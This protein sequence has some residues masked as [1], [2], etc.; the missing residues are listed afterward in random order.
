MLWVE[1]P[2]A[3]VLAPGR[4]CSPE[5]AGLAALVIVAGGLGRWVLSRR[6]ASPIV[7]LTAA[8]EGIAT[9]P[10]EA[11]SADASSDEGRVSPMRFNGWPNRVRESLATATA[12]RAEAEAQTRE[13]RALADR[14]RTAGRGG[15][16]AFG[17]S[18]SNSTN[19]CSCPSQEADAARA[20][21][22]AANGAKVEFLATNESRVANA[23][24]AIAG[25][26]D[27]LDAEVAGPVS[28]E[29]EKYLAR[30]ETGAGPVVET[31]R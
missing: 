20:D 10:D 26:V 4:L 7:L 24:N 9:A 15:P 30:I 27:L 17:G 23:T 13:A 11:P 14:A 12:A 5:I 2:A 25:F 3:D 16:S 8:A 18:S 31:N 28:E 22:E 19:A 21:A 29:Q 1:Q 6:I